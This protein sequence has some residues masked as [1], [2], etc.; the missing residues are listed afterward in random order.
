MN[1]PRVGSPV[2]HYSWPQP[3]DGGVR[4]GYFIALISMSLVMSSSAASSASVGEWRHR[5]DAGI[6]VPHHRAHQGG[7]RGDAWVAI[8]TGS[9]ALTGR[10]RA[11]L[12]VL[13]AI[14]PHMSQVTTLVSPAVNGS[15]PPAYAQAATVNTAPVA[16][17]A[18]AHPTKI[19]AHD[20]RCLSASGCCP[21]PSGCAS[22][23]R[24]SS[25]GRVWSP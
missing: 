16:R 17:L 1:F 14:G 20:R 21:W 8:D 9:C 3:G 6:S 12:A 15:P 7:F 22:P 23:W 2:E 10:R 25:P 19:R 24:C 13:A 18:S 11:G 5:T 4:W